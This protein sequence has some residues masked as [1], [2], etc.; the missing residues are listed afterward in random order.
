MGSSMLIKGERCFHFEFLQLIEP[1]YVYRYPT[2]GVSGTIIVSTRWRKMLFFFTDFCFC[3]WCRT[4]GECLLLGLK[5]FFDKKCVFLGVY[6]YEHPHSH[7]VDERDHEST[8]FWLDKGFDLPFNQ[9]DLNPLVIII[10]NY[11]CPLK[12]F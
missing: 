1:V 11:L 8:S 3:V 4:R 6:I 9:H 7:P 5:D 10:G 2:H 12:I